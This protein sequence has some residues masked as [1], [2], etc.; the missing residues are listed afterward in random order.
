[1]TVSM[2]R[3]RFLVKF[4]ELITLLI[5]RLLS[6]RDLHR[7]ST[8]GCRRYASVHE[9]T[10]T[11]HARGSTCKY[12]NKCWYGHDKLEES[13]RLQK[14]REEHHEHHRKFPIEKCDSREIKRSEHVLMMLLFSAITIVKGF[15][16]I[17]VYQINVIESSVITC[18]SVQFFVRH[19]YDK[20]DDINCWN[21][22]AWRVR[23][24]LSE[25]D[26][27][28]WIKLVLCHHLHLGQKLGSPYRPQLLSNSSRLVARP[29]QVQH[30]QERFSHN[31]LASSLLHFGTSGLEPDLQHALFIKDVDRSLRHKPISRTEWEINTGVRWNP[32]RCH[33][34]YGY[35]L[36][37]KD[38][39]A[40]TNWTV[41]NCCISKIRSPLYLKCFAP[42]GAG[43]IHYTLM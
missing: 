18:P 27:S 9:Y 22:I 11:L 6:G 4:L 8:A 41:F 29:V 32:F 1:M 28:Q 19:F 30:D 17:E 38:S 7:E 33:S 10:W 16:T 40:H 24:K 3:K 20:A 5:N 21:Q 26:Y 43:F 23:S 36:L 12:G 35:T 37:L 42:N 25:W 14:T 31:P 34:C 15:V 13:I 39:H 2:T